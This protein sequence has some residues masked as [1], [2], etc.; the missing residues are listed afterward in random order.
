MYAVVE[1]QG[2]QYIVKKWMK[3]RVDRLDD[4]AWL[5]VNPLLVFSDDGAQTVV[6]K[7]LL[8]DYN[9]IFSRIDD[10]KWDKIHVVKFK[11]KNRYSRKIWFRPHQTLLEV[12]DIVAH[13]KK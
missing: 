11:R 2:H 9:V 6:G 1:L 5:E 8:D 3:I 7:P 13:G 12:K 10:C 4:D